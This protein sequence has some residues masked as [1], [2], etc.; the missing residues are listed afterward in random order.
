MRFM[1][2]TMGREDGGGCSPASSPVGLLYNPHQLP[3]EEEKQFFS[4]I[5]QIVFDTYQQEFLT[6]LFS[7]VLEI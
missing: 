4:L 6:T 5:V 2:M 3:W 1:G 7:Q